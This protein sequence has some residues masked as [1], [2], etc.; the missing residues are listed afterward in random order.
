MPAP[1][2][3]RRLARLILV[4]A[5]LPIAAAAQPLPAGCDRGELATLPLTLSESGVPIVEARINGQPVP[6]ELDSGQQQ[7]THLDRQ[8]VERLGIKVQT[9]DTN[10]ARVQIQN[11]LIDRLAVGPMEVAKGWFH[12][13][14]LQRVGVRVGANLL[15]RHDVEIA[16]AAGYLRFFKPSGCYRAHLAYWEPKA[17]AV[18]FQKDQQRRDLRPWFK[19]RINGKD[20]DAV[21]STLDQHSYIDLYTARRMGLDPDAPGAAE[22]RS[23]K[24]WYDRVQ[25]VWR[26]PVPQMSIGGMQV[27]DFNLRL[28]NMDRSGEMLVLGLDFL[29]RH[30]VYVAM[31]QN[32]IYFTPVEAGATASGKQAASP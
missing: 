6:A 12:V 3:A 2:A 14:E 5:A 26:V 4:L 19:V 31:S 25:R 18:P 1:G 27:N 15:F 16:L 23:V 9:A 11:A 32:R 7:A 28:F 17:A 10:Y 8:T 20:I 24:S 29:K 30:R 22:E 13:D 21:I